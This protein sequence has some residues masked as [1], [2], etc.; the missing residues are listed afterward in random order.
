MQEPSKIQIPDVWN[1]SLRSLTHVFNEFITHIIKE[2]YHFIVKP[3]FSEVQFIY[4]SLNIKFMKN[5]VS[6][7]YIKK[8]FLKHIHFFLW[9]KS[10]NLVK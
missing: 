1:S 9:E 7:R 3:I 2:L 10:E 4:P 5:L 8:I 6:H